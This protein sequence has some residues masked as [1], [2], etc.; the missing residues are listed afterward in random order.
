M[1]NSV[2][3]DIITPSKEYVRQWRLHW[4]PL[5]NKVCN[6]AGNSEKVVNLCFRLYDPK[7]QTLCTS[8]GS[9]V[10]F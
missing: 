10:R 3:G 7:R 8:F 1:R 5:E 6:A 9:S 2:D 4:R